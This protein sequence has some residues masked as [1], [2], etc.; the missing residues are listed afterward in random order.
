[1]EIDFDRL[2]LQPSESD[3]HYRFKYLHRVRARIEPPPRHP[4]P[5]R[6]AREIRKNYGW[7][8][9]SFYPGLVES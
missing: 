3:S 6:I 5:E 8:Y 1:M 7:Y 4:A 9:R 2:E